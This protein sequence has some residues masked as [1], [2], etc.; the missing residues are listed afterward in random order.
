MQRLTS[1]GQ[2]TATRPRRQPP[3]TLAFLAGTGD[4]TA[5]L[6]LAHTARLPGRFVTAVE[7]SVTAVQVACLRTSA[8]YAVCARVAEGAGRCGAHVDG[9]QEPLSS[10]ASASAVVNCDDG[11][12]VEGHILA[13]VRRAASGAVAAGR[14]VPAF[15]ELRV[16]Q[17][18]ELLLV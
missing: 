2:C 14:V 16:V 15:H 7:R 9:A 5:A 10:A 12:S 17:V 1:R 4:L 3:I 6:L 11:G 18:S 13:A 8:H